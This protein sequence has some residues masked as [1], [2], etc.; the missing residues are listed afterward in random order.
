MNNKINTCFGLIR[1]GKTRWNLEKRIQGNNNLELCPEGIAQ[2]RNWGKF[3]GE[4]RQWDRIVTSNLQRTWETGRIINEDFKVPMEKD[5]RLDEQNWGNWNGKTKKDLM[6][7]HLK[8]LENQINS[9]WQFCPPGGEDRLSVWHRALD[10]FADMAGRFPGQNILV[11]THIGVIKSVIY[12]VLKRKFLPGE[13]MVL[14]PD[15][16]H[17][18]GWENEKL[19][20]KSLNKVCYSFEK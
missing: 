3:L 8:E 18:I 15:H 4:I 17:L 1:H 9:G 12:A 10:A 19:V 13:P 11:I 7:W 16:L 20:I 14:K 5:Y 6:K 2:V